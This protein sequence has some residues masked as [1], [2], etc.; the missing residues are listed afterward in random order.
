MSA[1]GE[2]SPEADVNSPTDAPHDSVPTNFF[3]R[4]LQDNLVFTTAHIRILAEDRYDK[5][6]TVLY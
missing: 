3:T 4:I 2:E 1:P 6:D 5:Q